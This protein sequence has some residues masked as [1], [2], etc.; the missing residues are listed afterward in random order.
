MRHLK[1][2]PKATNEVET[3]KLVEKKKS[4]S[5]SS[6]IAHHPAGS[7]SPLF[8]QETQYIISFPSPFFFDPYFFILSYIH[9]QAV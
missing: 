3:L 8:L 7:T 4:I 9:L 5:I 6:V 1:Y 2:K